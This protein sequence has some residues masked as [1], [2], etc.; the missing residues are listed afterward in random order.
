M[1]FSLTRNDESIN[2]KPGDIVLY[3]RNQMSIM[4]G[5][6]SRSH[7]KLGKLDIKL[8]NNLNEILGDGDTTITIKTMEG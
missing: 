5:S 8:I 1:C 7:T 3:N 2:A 6:N 4:Y